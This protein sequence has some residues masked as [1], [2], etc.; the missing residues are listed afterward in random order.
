MRTSPINTRNPHVGVVAAR[1]TWMPPISKQR[2]TQRRST[3][4]L[5]TNLNTMTQT[6]IHPTTTILTTWC[7]SLLPSRVPH[8]PSTTTGRPSPWWPRRN[9]LPGCCRACQRTS[10]CS[11]LCIHSRASCATWRQP[12]SVIAVYSTSTRGTP[13]ANEAKASSKAPQRKD[14]SDRA[15]VEQAIDPRTRRV[16]LHSPNVHCL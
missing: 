4:R 14:K 11:R 1:S 12:A 10:I 8:V 7:A 16:G 6:S 3:P 13:Q 5:S 9:T 2:R 15:T